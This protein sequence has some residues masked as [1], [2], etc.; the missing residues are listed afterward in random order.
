MKA[1]NTR[2]VV[3]VI[4]NVAALVGSSQIS[5]QEAADAGVGRGQYWRQWNHVTTLHDRCDTYKQVCSQ[6]VYS[7]TVQVLWNLSMHGFV[8]VVFGG[9][10]V[11]S[12]IYNAFLLVCNI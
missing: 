3:C 4:V 1:F 5:G 9:T 11:R 10:K 6:S 7:E 12:I 2:R 8:M